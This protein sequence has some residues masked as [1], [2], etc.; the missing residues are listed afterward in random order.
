MHDA[1]IR[2]KADAGVEEV[3]TGSG[4]DVNRRSGSA[5]EDPEHEVQERLREA[6]EPVGR[7]RTGDQEAVGGGGAGAD[8]LTGEAER[9]VS[10]VFDGTHEG[11]L[12]SVR[13][14]GWAALVVQSL[15]RTRDVHPESPGKRYGRDRRFFPGRGLS[16]EL[17]R[18][19]AFIFAA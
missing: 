15:V 5:V 1:G 13:G 14:A 16:A 7:G 9:T 3:R 19:K 11:P 12:S 17:T 2:P 8:D 6:Q 4:P 10:D 18:K